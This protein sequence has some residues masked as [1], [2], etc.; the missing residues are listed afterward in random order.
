M[1][2]LVTGAMEARKNPIS[3]KRPS[4]IPCRRLKKCNP[5]WPVTMCERRPARIG[6]P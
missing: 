5:L 6:I 2:H 4:N 1:D 3:A